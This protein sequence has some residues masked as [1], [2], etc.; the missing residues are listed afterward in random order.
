M[1][2]RCLVPRSLACCW[3]ARCCHCPWLWR[4]PSGSPLAV[5]ARVAAVLRAC[6]PDSWDAHCGWSLIVSVVRPRSC[7]CG[8]LGA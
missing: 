8:T 5:G 6:G 2:V 7:G 3:C 1:P 4:G